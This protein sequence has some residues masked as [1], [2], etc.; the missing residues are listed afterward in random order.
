MS[1]PKI[2]D[3]GAAFP[4]PGLS[5]LPNGEFL[6][7][8]N[9]MSLREYLMA[10]APASEIQGLVPGTGA[11]CA[12]SIG[13]PVSEYKFEVHYAEVLAVARRKWADAMIRAAGEPQ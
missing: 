4:V 13:V 8:T 11:K 6:H 7:P 5:N 10:H 2:H 9:G 1:A 3:G 12:A